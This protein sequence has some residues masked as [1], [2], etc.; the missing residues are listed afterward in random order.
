MNTQ[1][2][3]TWINIKELREK[4]EFEKVLTRYDVKVIRKGVQH[5]GPCPLPG[6][7]GSRGGSTFSANLERG[8]F[9]CFGCKA[10]GNALEFACLMEGIDIKDGNALRKVA[11]KLRGA[12]FQE[13][14]VVETKP[15][16]PNKEEEATLPIVLVN[17]PLDFELKG[18]EHNH[19]AVERLGITLA[20]AVHFGV[21]FCSRG[22]LKDR[23]AIPIHDKEGRLVGYAGRLAD[24][25]LVSA[26]APL[27]RYPSSRT[28]DGITLDFQKDALLYNAHRIKSQVKT[29]VVVPDYQF[30]WRLVE[31]GVLRVVAMMDGICSMQQAELL[32]E[33]GR[34]NGSVIVFAPASAGMWSSAVFDRLGRRR[35]VRI[36]EV[37]NDSAS[38]QAAVRTIK[39][40][41][42]SDP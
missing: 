8:I 12:F 25:S 34:D 18:L 14:A 10:K 9:Q 27:Y 20:T 41:V 40:L 31:N 28:K 15:P 19:P 7:T 24:E 33:L 17:Q 30:A 23:V 5:A 22:F 39:S 21:G 42:A 37:G 16:P 13:E 1:S 32:S 3:R 26:D 29:L 35:F 11:V 38:F 36:V 6:H 2:G 4:L